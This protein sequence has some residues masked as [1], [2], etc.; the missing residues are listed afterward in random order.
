MIPMQ[1]N[2][3]SLFSAVEPLNRRSASKG[4]GLEIGSRLSTECKLSMR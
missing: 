3:S 1:A 2:S 4:V